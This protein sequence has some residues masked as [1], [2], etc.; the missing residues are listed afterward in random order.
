MGDNQ[1]FLVFSKDK[2]CHISVHTPIVIL[3]VIQFHGQTCLLLFYGVK[4]PQELAP[5]DLLHGQ[6]H[7]SSHYRVFNDDLLT[8]WLHFLE[9]V[10]PLGH[11]P[12]LFSRWCLV[13]TCPRPNYRDFR[14]WEIVPY[15]LKMGSHFWK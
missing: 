2:I 6:D 5:R 1:H 12:D 15:D 10:N 8:L 7:E 9:K 13:V 11:F 3:I 4:W 14:G